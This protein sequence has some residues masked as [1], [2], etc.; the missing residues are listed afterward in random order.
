MTGAAST[1]TNTSRS[2]GRGVSTLPTDSCSSPPGVTRLRS[3]RMVAGI[4]DMAV[5]SL[6]VNS[7]AA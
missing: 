5:P 6:Q 4:S 2:V 7:S 3:W 1:R